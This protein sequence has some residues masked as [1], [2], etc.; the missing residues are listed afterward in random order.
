MPR[1]AKVLG[2]ITVCRRVPPFAVE[3]RPSKAALQAMFEER[4]AI[5]FP[6]WQAALFAEPWTPEKIEAYRRQA[7]SFLRRC[8]VTHAAATIVVIR[9]HSA[10]Q[11]QQGAKLARR[12]PDPAERGPSSRPVESGVKPPHSQPSLPA[13]PF[14]HSVISVFQIHFNRGRR[15]R[16]ALPL[17][18]PFSSA[19]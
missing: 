18:F 13:L 6:A 12:D 7:L 2:D 16:L 11:K 15:A 1:G 4:P 3:L 17:Q 5:S 14:V 19:F 9:P 8:K 10:A